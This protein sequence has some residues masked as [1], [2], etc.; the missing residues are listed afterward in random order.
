MYWIFSSGICTGFP[1]KQCLISQQSLCP[2]IVGYIPIKYHKIPSIHHGKSRQPP[3]KNNPTCK[4]SGPQAPHKRVP[5]DWRCSEPKW[6]QS[7]NGPEIRFRKR[8]KLWWKHWKPILKGFFPKHHFRLALVARVSEFPGATFTEACN[9]HDQ[10]HW[11]DLRVVFCSQDLPTISVLNRLTEKS[12]ALIMF[13]T[14]LT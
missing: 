9:P 10:T 14:F 6:Q 4:A 1:S 8:P 7:D 11:T 13:K 12:C 3:T 2:V 5:R